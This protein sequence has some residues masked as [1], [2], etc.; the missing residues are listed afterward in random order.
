MASILVSARCE[1]ATYCSTGFSAGAASRNRRVIAAAPS[2]SRTTSIPTIEA[3]SR[4]TAVNTEK[5]PPT[6]SGMPNTSG[7]PSVWA[8]L[9]SLP[10][11]PVIGT[12]RSASR[13][14]SWPTAS[15]SS[16]RNSRVATAVSSVPPLLLTTSR[17]HWVNRSSASARSAGANT[18]S[19]PWAESLSILK[20]SNDSRG[21]PPR[22]PR[23]SSL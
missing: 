22:S 2:N 8:R 7:H 23:D 11:A 16:R 19:S 3:G 14:G 6:P 17:A 5:R 21:L 9:A 13:A 4:P 15:A 18:S 12:S 1:T 10:L 20:P